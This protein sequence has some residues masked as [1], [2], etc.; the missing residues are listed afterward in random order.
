M[1]ALKGSVLLKAVFAAWMLLCVW[2]TARAEEIYIH[3]GQVRVLDYANPIKR[4]SITT[5]EV[6]DASVTSSRQILINGKTAGKTSLVIWDE[7]EHFTIYPIIVRREP[8][9]YQIQLNVKFAEV[10]K[11]IL[12]ELGSDWLIKNQKIGSEKATFG[13]F[14]GK[15]SQPND[16]LQ[17][18]E[19]VDLFLSIPSRDISAIFKAL[20][21]KNLLTV[22]ARP[23]LTTLDGVEASFLA[24]G[25]FPIPIVSGA[26]GLQTVTIQ[27]KEFGIRL[28]FTPTMLDSGI[29]NLQVATEVSS[30]DF[31]NGIILSGFRIPALKT[32]K[33]D[34][35]IEMKENEFLVIGGLL[36][37]DMAKTLSKIPVIGS[38][39]ILGKFFSSTR[40]LKDDT[41]LIV[42]V[43]PK[44]AHTI[45]ESEVPKLKAE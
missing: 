18:G 5:P 6:A 20:E 42:V 35:M 4:I 10:E 22:L 9:P 23:N 14:A 13:S 33:T 44:I 43:S 40:Y 28:K 39:P 17:L 8:A 11:N 19:T 27:F 41:E 21:E 31:E 26:A 2:T 34:T 32:R 45:T 3:L 15:V 25:E 7:N 36:A 24:G 16:P 38:I 12:K 37:S 1:S 29:I 30:L